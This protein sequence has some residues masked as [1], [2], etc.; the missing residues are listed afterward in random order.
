LGVIAEEQRDL[1]GAERWYLKSLAISEKQ[2]N[3]HSAAATYHQLGKIAQERGDHGKAGELFLKAF[4]VF[5]RK[6]DKHNAGIALRSFAL[7]LR[8]APA[9]AREELRALGLKA[10]G[11]ELL[12]RVEKPASEDSGR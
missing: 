11:K 2:G 1:A 12:E 3:E 5:A 4:G 7:L 6:N 8:R 9:A 10:L